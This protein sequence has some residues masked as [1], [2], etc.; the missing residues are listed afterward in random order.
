MGLPA[1]KG[2]QGATV[3]MAALVAMV[4]AGC[5]SKKPVVKEEKK[6][7]PVKVEPVKVVAPLAFGK[8]YFAYNLSNLKTAG[9]KTLKRAVD[10]LLARPNAKINIEGH[11]DE[12]GTDEYNIDLGWKRAYAVRDYLKRLGV[13]ENRMFPTSYGR[14]R[15]AATGS[16]ESAWSKNRRVEI[17]ERK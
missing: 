5:V 6:P 15:P 1:L 13:D 2:W 11:C 14:A 12:R 7:E 9:R 8:I 17:S 16:D 3:A 10:H 4:M